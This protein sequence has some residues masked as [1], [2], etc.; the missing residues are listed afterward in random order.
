VARFVPH[1]GSR[2]PDVGERAD[3][4]GRPGSPGSPGSDQGGAARP[5]P[6]GADATTAALAPRAA[7]ALA[8][9]AAETQVVR[10]GAEI[11]PG[12][13]R[14]TGPA[15]GGPGLTPL[16][17]RRVAAE[18]GMYVG[19]GLVALSLVGV[20]ARG[21]SD[22]GSPLRVG[23]L[24]LA[25]LGLL[26]SGLFVRLPW[27]RSVG[28]ERRRAVST[29]LTAGSVLALTAM[30]VLLGVGG[31]P[32]VALATIH[33][34]LAVGMLLAVCAIARTALS[35]VALLGSLA[36]SVVLLAPIGPATWTMLVVLGALWALLAWRGARGKRTAAVS[37]AVLV[38]VASV[39]LAQGSWAW[40]VRGA[41]ATLIVACLVVFARGGPNYWLAL[42]AGAAA[43]LA[44]SVAGG[45]LGPALAL[46]VGG[47]ST[48]VVSAIALRTAGRPG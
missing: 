33:A 38:L 14:P 12:G 11:R 27:S 39:G 30:G 21:W 41:L 20:A 5:A 3:I 40:P 6:T 36:W 35:E 43:A 45:I 25:A 24:G 8:D 37:G 18:V 47:L 17:G 13:Q 4:E 1:P 42:G 46:L 7:G 23:T 10:A 32:G 29:M 26:A 22:W 31:S 9:P 34:V 28:E 48:M 15:D 19:A 44:A 2:T 16:L